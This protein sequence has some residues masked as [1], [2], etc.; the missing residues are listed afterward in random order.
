M[1]IVILHFNKNYTVINHSLVKKTFVCNLCSFGGFIWISVSPF[2]IHK[3]GW[4]NKSTNLRLKTAVF[5]HKKGKWSVQGG[6]L[7]FSYVNSRPWRV[8][9][10]VEWFCARCVLMF[11]NFKITRFTHTLECHLTKNYG[12]AL[13]FF[14]EVVKGFDMTNLFA[15]FIH[16]SDKIK[17]KIEFMRRNKWL[18]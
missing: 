17:R 14:P 6:R 18:T 13:L 8:S 7:V 12:N 1:S 9:F 4:I 16:V 2:S 5:P 15:R 3:W 10:S 11:A